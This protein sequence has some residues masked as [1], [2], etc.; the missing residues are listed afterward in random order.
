MSLRDQYARARSRRTS[1]SGKSSKLR[2]KRGDYVTTSDGKTIVDH[3]NTQRSRLRVDTRKWAAARLA[4]KKYGDHISHDV[5]GPGANF[6]PAILITVDGQ[7]HD[8]FAR[9]LAVASYSTATEILCERAEPEFRCR[10]GPCVRTLDRPIEGQAQHPIQND[11][12]LAQGPA[13][14]SVLG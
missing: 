5:K 10:R 12:G 13:N 4:P 3:E 9:Q 6:Q 11:S 2:T 1:S 7:P 14:P 8:E